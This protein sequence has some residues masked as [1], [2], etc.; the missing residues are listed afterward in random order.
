LTI[1]NLR[2]ITISSKNYRDRRFTGGHRRYLEIIKCLNNKNIVHLIGP[3]E[4]PGIILTGHFF[5]INYKRFMVNFLP[6]IVVHCFYVLW[7][8]F[9]NFKKLKNANI[10]AIVVVSLQNGFP[11][12]ILKKFLKSKVILWIF[13]DPR[14]Y[15]ELNILEKGIRLINRIVINN[16]FLNKIYLSIF[17]IIEKIVLKKSDFIIV[18]SIYYKNILSRRIGISENKFRVLYNNINPSWMD[19]SLFNSNNSNKLNNICFV[20]GLTKRKGILELIQAFIDVGEKYPYLRLYVVGEGSLSCKLKR[21]V[22]ENK[23]F[24][25]KI[26]FVGWVDNPLK[27]I[28]KSDLLIVPSYSESFPEVI[29]ESLFV[30]TPVLGTNVGGIPEQ[31]LYDE[32]LFEPRNK[33]SIVDKL[34]LLI[35]DN[36]HYMKI[37]ALCK[38]RA[39]ELKFNW[40]QQI[41][42][43][44]VEMLNA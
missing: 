20:G 34:M 30:G 24:N 32:L 8:V 31:L 1:T 23:F 19:L 6:H 2:I 13:S 22:L 42:N 41:Q 10:S 28:A 27:I 38:Q 44:L 36:T 26:K 40:C 29:G 35:L 25:E 39:K 18:Q 17:S 4:L 37:K 3:S 9:K 15:T 12:I 21:I 7:T 14:E 5:K 33:K 16:Q 11:A 43:M